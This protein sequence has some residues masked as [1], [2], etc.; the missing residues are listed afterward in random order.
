M[1]YTERP[2]LK[3]KTNEAEIREHQ[4]LDAQKRQPRLSKYEKKIAKQAA[5]E[6]R[7]AQTRYYSQ[8]GQGDAPW[9]RRLQVWALVAAIVGFVVIGILASG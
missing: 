7:L 8:S 3:R 4:I 2:N 5:A 9:V 6:R 1:P